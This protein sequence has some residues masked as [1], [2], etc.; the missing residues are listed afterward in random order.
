MMDNP[1]GS[2]NKD[3]ILDVLKK[4]IDT[5]KQSNLLEISSGPGL[6]AHY[7]AQKF[8]K[9][10]FQPSEFLKAFF[11]SINA[12]RDNCP[13]NNVLEP[14]FIDISLGLEHWEGMFGDENLKDCENTFDYMLSINMI[15][16]T[17]IECSKGLF[18]NSSKLLKP[19]GLLFTYGSYKED[20]VPEPLSNFL[21]DQHLRS[22][23]PSWGLRNIAELENF[24][25][26][27]SMQLHA[28]YDLPS[29]NKCL[30]WMKN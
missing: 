29:D 27:N 20:G 23:D 14:T 26:E 8:P 11:P 6:H 19:R 10:T 15:H 22:N 17:P 24:A 3:W 1:A 9:M 25:K 21:F 16:I 13:T 28:N 2:R 12:Y 7:Y 18:V 5:E 30:V 4:Y